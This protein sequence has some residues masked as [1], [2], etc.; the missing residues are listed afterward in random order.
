LETKKDVFDYFYYKITFK[1]LMMIINTIVDK[2]YKFIFDIILTYFFKNEFKVI[3]F[4]SFIAKI[5]HKVKTLSNKNPTKL[6]SIDI[7]MKFL[8]F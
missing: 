8:D 5:K 1:E 3:K 7:K 2:K 6:V 4:H